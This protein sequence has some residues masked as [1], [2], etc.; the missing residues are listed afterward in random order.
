VDRLDP[1]HDELSWERL[2]EVKFKGQS[3]T[4]AKL[5]VAEDQPQQRTIDSTPA[6][7]TSQPNEVNQDLTINES[8]AHGKNLCKRMK[9]NN[10][11]VQALQ[12][13]YPEDPLFSKILERPKDHPAFR[14]HNGLIW[15]RNVNKEWVVCLPRGRVDRQMI[16]GL[17]IDQAHTVLGHFRAQRTADYIHRWYWW[18]RLQPDVQSFC[19]TCVMCHTTK[20]TNSGQL[21]CYTRF[22]CQTG[23]GNQLEWT[24]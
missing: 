11:F 14:Q 21:D 4:L 15:T 7:D 9:Q 10:S 17:V 19:D 6:T 23:P 24:S 5:A 3:A 8:R 18:P 12:D 16:R 22:Q 1:N 20:D 2:C 13:N